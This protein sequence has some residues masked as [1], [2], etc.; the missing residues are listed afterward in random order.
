MLTYLTVSLLV[1]TVLWL[2]SLACESPRCRA[3]WRRVT[4][5]ETERYLGDMRRD[6]EGPWGLHDPSTP[7]D[8]R[9]DTLAES[10]DSEE[11][12]RVIRRR[13]G[14]RAA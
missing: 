4:E 6:R 14:G 9:G 1:V 13:R 10:P 5:T 2:L 7:P 3:W 8:I 11:H 12:S